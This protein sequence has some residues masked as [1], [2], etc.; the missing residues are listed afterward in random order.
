MNEVKTEKDIDG[1]AARAKRLELKIKQKP[2]WAAVGVGQTGGSKFETE[3]SNRLTKPVRILLFARYFA[4][5]EID[6]T[7][8]EGVVELSRLAQ[9]Q[10]SA[11]VIHQD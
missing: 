11:R 6:A 7:T 5:L 9:H 8:P 2:F 3:R 1:A 10:R 4:G